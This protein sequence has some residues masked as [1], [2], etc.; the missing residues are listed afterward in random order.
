MPKSPTAKHKSRSVSEIADPRA[1]R[2]RAQISAAFA[3]LL[4]RRPYARIRVSEITRKAQVGRAT[5]YAHFDS[6]DSLLRAELQ[7]VVR[8]MITPLPGD[9]CPADCT[10][11][12]AH[13]QHAEALYRHLMGGESRAV[14]ERIVQE[15]LEERIVQII[16]SKPT[17]AGAASG[18]AFVP[19]FIASTLTALISWSLE[20]AQRP[21]PALLQK[22]YATLVGSALAALA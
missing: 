12:F 18:T 14:C 5:F 1:E 10:A 15:A 7:R 22:L 8:P 17:P 13:L 16:S 21:S 11:L 19:R 4:A 6:K 3:Q 2:T 20:Q 9:S